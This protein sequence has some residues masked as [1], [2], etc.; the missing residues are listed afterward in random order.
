MTDK[1]LIS[2]HV[3]VTGLIKSLPQSAAQRTAAFGW[4]INSRKP[5]NVLSFAAVTVI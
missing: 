3:L 5:Y 4:A 2:S 1:V